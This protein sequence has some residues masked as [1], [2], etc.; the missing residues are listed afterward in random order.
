MIF[1]PQA[2]RRISD[3]VQA[4]DPASQALWE[5]WAQTLAPNQIRANAPHDIIL[6][7]LRALIEAEQKI[8]DQ[9]NLEDPDDDLKADLLNDLVY[10]RAIKT[11]PQ[12]CAMS[13]SP[14]GP[15][16]MDVLHALSLR[17]RLSLVQ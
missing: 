4:L 11:A 7:A 10:V 6:I 1:T 5:T 2:R 14:F 17:I 8:V 15:G 13:G 12:K 16:E 3:A 9:L